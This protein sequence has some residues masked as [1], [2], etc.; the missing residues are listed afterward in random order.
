MFNLSTNTF[1]PKGFWDIAIDQTECPGPDSLI[2]FDQTGYHLCSLEQQYADANM[3]PLEEQWDGMAM[4]KDWFT[5]ERYT[6]PH[7]NHGYLY[8]RKGFSGN[9]LAQLENWAKEN[10]LLHKL[11]HIQ[12]KW[13]IDFS[14]DYVDEHKENTMELFHYEWDDNNLDAVLE[15]KEIIEHIVFK[16][17]WEDFAKYKIE[18]KDEWIHL[19]YKEQSAWTT[20]KLNLPKEKAE[21]HIWR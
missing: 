15:K 3:Q 4:S 16:T 18:H 6:G 17:D 21:L 12:P 2:R 9:A 1:N 14:L 19:L 8:E 20:K 10:H 11:S 13:G 7:I 5:L